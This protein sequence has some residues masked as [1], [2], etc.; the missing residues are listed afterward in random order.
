M[1]RLILA[2]SVTETRCFL[3]QDGNRKEAVNV[4]RFTATSNAMNV[5]QLVKIQHPKPLG[6][7]SFQNGERCKTR[8]FGKT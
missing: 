2:R 1:K 7:M 6:Q 5:I 3:I 4:K 8:V